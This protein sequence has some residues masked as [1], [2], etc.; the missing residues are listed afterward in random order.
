V[1]KLG[2][3]MRT[4]IV[5]DDKLMNL[6]LKA[7]KFNS[8]REAVENGLKLLIQMNSQKK[9]LGLEGKIQWEGNLEEMRKD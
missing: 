1:Y 2:G 7:G 4:N 9:L 6:A 3:N 5:I 8:K